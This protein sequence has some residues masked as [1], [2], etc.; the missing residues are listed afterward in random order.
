MSST[1][2]TAS[3]LQASR[4][5]FELVEVGRSLC[6]RVHACVCVHESKKVGMQR[7]EACSLCSALPWRPTHI[8]HHATSRFTSTLTNPSAQLP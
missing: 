7:T 2:A 5:P 1:G 8:P 3:E 4:L 6:A